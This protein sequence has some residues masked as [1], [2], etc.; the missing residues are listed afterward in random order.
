MSTEGGCTDESGKPLPTHSCERYLD[1]DQHADMGRL[2]SVQFNQRK[3]N[4]V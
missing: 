2:M 1:S 4:G 3:G